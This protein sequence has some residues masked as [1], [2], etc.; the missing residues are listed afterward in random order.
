[1]YDTGST[2]EFEQLNGIFKNQQDF[3]KYEYQKPGPEEIATFNIP[4]IFNLKDEIVLLNE[5]KYIFKVQVS[6]YTFGAFA[7]RLRYA[8]LGT[9]EKFTQ[10]TFDKKLKYII[11]NISLKIKKR[12]FATLGKINVVKENILTEK[13]RFYYI[14]GDKQNILQKHKKLIAGLLI[15][16][17][18]I[19]TLENDYVDLVLKKNITYDTTNILFVGW[20]SAVMIDKEY[21]YEHELLMAEIANLELLETRIQHKKLVET[22]KIINKDIEKINTQ[23]FL[24][25]GNKLRKINESLSR[26][27]ENSKLILN[28]VE[29][30]AYG[31]GEWYLSRVYTLFN[32]VFKLNNLENILEKDMEAIA[33]EQ[34]FVED[35]ITAIHEN[36]L[37]YIVIILIAIEIIIE[38][39]YLLK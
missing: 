9:Y 3:S 21:I 29:D 11:N 32:E 39:L 38:V 33:N 25:K 14:N 34:R 37:E 31:Y 15:D 16:E 8:F 28:N 1:M 30:T 6:V 17:D 5:I 27:Y 35:K 2:F 24:L 7:I 18:E 23:R 10:L 12:V 22:L 13:Y 36:F 26:N 20:E 4:V 19:F